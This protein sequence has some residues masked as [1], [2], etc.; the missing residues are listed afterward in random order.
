MRKEKDYRSITIDE[1][2]AWVDKNCFHE[3]VRKRLKSRAVA[4]R[5]GTHLLIAI[6]YVADLEKRIAELE[7]ELANKRKKK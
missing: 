3:D 7:A 4:W 5:I 6:N 2:M 1:A